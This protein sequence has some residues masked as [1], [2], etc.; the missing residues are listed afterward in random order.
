MAHSFSYSFIVQE[1]DIDS[2]N[3]VNNLVY[4]KWAHAISA[5]HW[6][7]LVPKEA[8]NLLWVVGKQEIEYLQELILDDEV[9]LETEIIAINKHK[10]IRQIHFFKLP[11]HTKVATCF[12]TWVALDKVTKKPVRVSESVSKI[13]LQ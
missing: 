3:H 11:I 5:S 1:K 10:C 4:L 7:S 12:I 6:N 13:F 9:L 8:E 2:N